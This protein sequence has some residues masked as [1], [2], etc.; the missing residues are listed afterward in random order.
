MRH[1]NFCTQ[2][3]LYYSLADCGPPPLWNHGLSA[4][5]NN[6]YAGSVAVYYCEDVTAE[7]VGENVTALCLDT[8][9]WDAIPPVCTGKGIHS[10]ITLLLI[11][12]SL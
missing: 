10:L 4:N 2:T 8:G 6:T 12:V 1:C 11:I 5:Y 3:F 7:M 9:Q